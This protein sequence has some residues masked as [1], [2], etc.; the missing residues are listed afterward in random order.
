MF[1]PKCG[2]ENTESTQLCRNC[3]GLLNLPSISTTVQE[4]DI[5][6]SGEKYAGFWIRFLSVLIDGVILSAINFVIAIAVFLRP[7]SIAHRPHTSIPS[8]TTMCLRR[9]LGSEIRPKLPDIR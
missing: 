4:K 7:S 9:S 5:Y 3:G 1:C 8:P 2:A 6:K